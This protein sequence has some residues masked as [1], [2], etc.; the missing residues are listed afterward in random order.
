MHSSAQ[1]VLFGMLALSDLDARMRAVQ[2]SLPFPPAESI[3]EKKMRRPQLRR[4]AA[5]SGIAMAGQTP[6]AMD[7]EP[8]LHAVPC[9]SAATRQKALRELYQPDAHQDKPCG[10]E[11]V[12]G[13]YQYSD[14]P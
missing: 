10:Q 5:D 1:L 13:S 4:E 3:I 6:V 11:N 7:G 12:S 8:R 9:S 2:V 14:G